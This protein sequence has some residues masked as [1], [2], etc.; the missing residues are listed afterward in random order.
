M[1]QIMTHLRNLRTFRSLGARLRKTATLADDH[2]LAF[3]SL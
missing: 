2:W 1:T 3:V